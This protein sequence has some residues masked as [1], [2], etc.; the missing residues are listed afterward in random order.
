MDHLRSTFSPSSP[1][2]YD[3]LF[4]QVRYA[5]LLVLDDL[6]TQV[7][8][9]WADEKLY[10]IVASRY[11]DRLPTVITSVESVDELAQEWPNIGSRLVD[12]SLVDW[13]PISAPNYVDQRRHGAGS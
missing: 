3:E 12:Q 10:Q 5:D 7:S 9:P 1:I 11:D 6:G 8:T 13:H 2:R 4:E